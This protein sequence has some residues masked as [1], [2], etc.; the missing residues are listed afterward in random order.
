MHHDG[1]PAPTLR[2]LPSY[3]RLL[4]D[5]EAL[6]R[7]WVSCTHLA[8]SLHLDATQVRK[9]LACTGV[10]GRPKMGYQVQVLVGAIEHF[11][12]WST[13]TPAFLVGAGNMG[14]AL[15]GFPSFTRQ[16]LEIVAAFDVDPSRIGI[17]IQGR[18]VH[19]MARL[20]EQVAET[21]VRLGILTVPEAA[22]HEAAVAMRAAGL[23]A[24]WNFTPVKLALDGVVIEAVDLA[25]SFAVL[26]HRLTERDPALAE[27]LAQD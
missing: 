21:G 5:M 1:I 27:P 17:A 26:S 25:A 15:L 22:A 11:L 19:P 3:L 18:L 8:E 13:V 12:G 24:I 7:T 4:R 9:D 14:R 23:K 2:R 6:G 16:G 20:A 10:I